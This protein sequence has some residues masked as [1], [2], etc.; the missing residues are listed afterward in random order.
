MTNQ[1][2]ATIWGKHY[3][4]FLHTVAQTYPVYPNDVTKRKYHDLIM[5]FPLFIPDEKMG[6]RFSELLDK[7]P[8][9]PY[10]SNRESFIYWMIFIHNRVNVLLGKPEISRKKAIELY[11][12]NYVPKELD[13]VAGTQTKKSTVAVQIGIILAL[14][15]LAYL[16]WVA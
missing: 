8:V 15:I 5:N 2:D 14:I 3:W 1:F 9:T 10:L 12:A 13:F 6:N 11:Y 16:L 4:F 7:Y